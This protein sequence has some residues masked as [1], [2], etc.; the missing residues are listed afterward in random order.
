MLS[1]SVLKDSLEWL[2]QSLVT[3]EQCS[4]DN[5]LV[6]VAEYVMN[7]LASSC[8]REQGKIVVING[9]IGYNV[10]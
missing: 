9:L 6:L 4:L 2:K 8:S 1:D 7:G 3:G 10:K 5:R